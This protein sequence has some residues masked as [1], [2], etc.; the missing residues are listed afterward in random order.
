MEVRIEPLSESNLEEAIR[1]AESI[2][3]PDSPEPDLRSHFSGSI[4]PEKFSDFHAMQRI[5]DSKYWVAVETNNGNRVVGT[6]G[7]YHILEGYKFNETPK[8]DEVWLAEF[9]VH[10]D[11]RGNGI[12][13]DLLKL[14]INNANE[15]HTNL[16]LW[17]TN[18][19][20]DE[21]KAQR[22]YRRWGFSTFREFPNYN[23][24]PYK[25]IVFEKKLV[26]P[27]ANI[28]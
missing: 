24:K 22:I 9:G 6:I 23:S 20:E 25:V 28:L 18:D 26:I 7:L 13:R 8:P 5:K 12:G 4:Y 27:A 2:F 16:K 14:A 11:Y 19:S 21:I 15:T 3:L 10:K 1:L 17:T